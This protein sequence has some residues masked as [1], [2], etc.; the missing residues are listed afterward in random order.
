MAVFNEILTG[1]ISRFAQKHFSIK[2]RAPTPTLS[3]DVGMTMQIDSGAEN[4]YLQGWELFGAAATLG[5]PGAGNFLVIEL[6]NPPTSGVVAV[7]TN[8]IIAETTATTVAAPAIMQY[9]RGATADQN[10]PISTLA[11]DHRSRPNASLLLTRNSAAAAAIGGTSQTV[12]LVTGAANAEQDLLPGNLELPL[13]PGDAVTLN[14]G[15]VNDPCAFAFWWRER[16]L[17][18]SERT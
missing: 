6:R 9:I 13:L 14:A 8:A 10:T 1:R 15:T 16:P 11:F 3:A 17:E 5:A 12:S 18:E 2:G 7:V 4:R